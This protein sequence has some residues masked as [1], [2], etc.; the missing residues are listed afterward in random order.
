MIQFPTGIRIALVSQVGKYLP[1]NVAHYVAR[2]GLA[3]ASGVKLTDSGIATIAEILAN[4]FGATLV[5]SATML[6]DPAPANGLHI[7]LASGVVIPAM[8]GSGVILAAAALLCFTKLPMSALFAASACFVGSFIFAGLSF[9]AVVSSISPIVL[10]PMASIGIYAVAWTAGYV[11]PG[12]PAG[13]G[14]REAILV[15]W[16]APII[17]GGPAIACSLLHR[18]ISACVDAMVAIVGYAWFRISEDA[19]NLPYSQ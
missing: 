9:F 6:L 18:V 8:L 11:V 5:A 19:N 3:S 7:A 10:S 16:L 15:A 12:A 13:L 17:G 2:A 1:G 4:L 14:M